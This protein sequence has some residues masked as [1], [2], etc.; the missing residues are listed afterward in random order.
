MSPELEL[1][2]SQCGQPDAQA[3][4]EEILCAACCHERGSCGAV[5]EI[6]DPNNLLS[7][8][9]VIKFAPRQAG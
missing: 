1:T 3:V 7:E 5:R 8:P 4:G 6:P 2:C 9:A